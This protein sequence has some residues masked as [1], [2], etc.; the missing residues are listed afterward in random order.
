MAH[1]VAGA[2]IDENNVKWLI[3]GKTIA[4]AQS[5][6]L[7]KLSLKGNPIISVEP[8]WLFNYTNRLPFITLRIQTQVKRE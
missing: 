8:T 3:H 6:L 1:G 5:V 2:K 7:Q 4:E